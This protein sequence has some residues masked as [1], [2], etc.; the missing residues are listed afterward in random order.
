MMMRYLSR[1]EC[2]VAGRGPG[3][4]VPHVDAGQQPVLANH[5]EVLAQSGGS[6]ESQGLSHV[7]PESRSDA[8][9]SE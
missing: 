7:D 2:G 1:V 3:L 8:Q 5:L 4:R 6:W 9:T